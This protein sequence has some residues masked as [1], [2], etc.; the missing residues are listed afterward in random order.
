MT[1]TR[2][3]IRWAALLLVPLAISWRHLPAPL[4]FDDVQTVLENPRIRDS[5]YI[6][7]GWWPPYRAPVYVLHAVE[8]ALWGRD[9]AGYR[10][11]SLLLHLAAAAALWR[12]LARA[13]APRMDAESAERTAFWGAFLFAVHPVALVSAAGTVSARAEV[14]AAALFL[15]SAL[16]LWR[17]TESGRSATGAGAGLLAALS[18]LSKPAAAALLAGAAGAAR[19]AWRR[20][21]AAAGVAIALL[22]AGILLFR[23]VADRFQE[24]D[25]AAYWASQPGAIVRYA[26]LCALPSGL[27]IDHDLHPGDAGTGLSLP[28]AG[29]LLA[30]AAGAWT[31]RRRMFAAPRAAGWILLALL[32][33]AAS[34]LLDVLVDYRAYLAAAAVTALLAFAA[35]RSGPRGW[36]VLALAAALFALGSASALSRRGT[37]LGAWSDNARR[38]PGSARVYANVGQALFDRA[39]PRRAIRAFRAGLRLSP[40]QHV[41]E[42]SEEI[43]A[44]A[45]IFQNLG[46]AFY[47]TGDLG[48]AITCFRKGYVA[49]RRTKP[50]LLLNLAS[51]YAE[52]G[53]H[54][55]AEQHLEAYLAERPQDA[56]ALNLLGVVKARKGETSEAQGLWNYVQSLTFN[57]KDGRGEPRSLHNLANLVALDGKSGEAMAFYG[58]ALGRSGPEPGDEITIRNMLLLCVKAGDEKGAEQARRKLSEL[59]AP[60]EWLKPPD[61]LLWR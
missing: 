7:T 35:A 6:L 2:G 41:E 48:N 45:R 34:P 58:L 59:G 33:A 5:S 13:L 12:I 31:L 29:L 49:S 1:G 23:P 42:A 30:A 19:P 8:H 21:R 46:V 3:W 24:T 10:A 11:V 25:A 40:L 56:R 9:P 37:A 50:E 54:R 57:P 26:A 17:W 22:A 53:E 15:L 55:A 18:L 61:A 43:A 52:R 39:D 4:L 28:A 38:S 51:A 16:L 60:P 32:P 20:G 14:Q 44:H 36:R 47:Q 27:R